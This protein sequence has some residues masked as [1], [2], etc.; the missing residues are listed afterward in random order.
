MLQTSANAV[1]DIRIPRWVSEDEETEAGVSEA[2]GML[3]GEEVAAEAGVPQ[4]ATPASAGTAGLALA[5]TAATTAAA[6]AAPTQ[7]QQYMH[8]GMTESDG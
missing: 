2:E 7:G 5:A 8:Q 1:R 3:S 4:A 6:V